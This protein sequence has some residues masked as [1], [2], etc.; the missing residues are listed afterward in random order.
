MGAATGVAP[1]D[2]VGASAAGVVSDRTEALD[3]GWSRTVDGSFSQAG[4]IASVS[5]NK[6][7]L[8]RDH[9]KWLIILFILFD[10]RRFGST[11]AFVTHKRPFA[12]DFE[13]GQAS[14][15]AL[16]LP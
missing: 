1:L 2:A 8:V 14:A 4:A 11:R 15:R 9:L 6:T 12:A 5:A 16:A 7:A 10:A 13:A 3:E